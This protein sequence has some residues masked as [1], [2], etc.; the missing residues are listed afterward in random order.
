MSKS[1]SLQVVEWEKMLGLEKSVG[2]KKMLSLK[3][4]EVPRILSSKIL[5]I[6]KMLGLK[7]FEFEKILGTKDFRSNKFYPKTFLGLKKFLA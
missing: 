1:L 5:W 6:Q 3:K 4:F 7:N 2:S